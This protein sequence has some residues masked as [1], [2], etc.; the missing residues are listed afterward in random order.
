MF[1]PFGNSD[2]VAPAVGADFLKGANIHKAINAKEW[3]DYKR[4]HSP[5]QHFN[6]CNIPYLANGEV[7]LIFFKEEKNYSWL[8]NTAACFLVKQ[9]YLQSKHYFK[10]FF[11]NF[12]FFVTN[13]FFWRR[14]AQLTT[15]V[16]PNTITGSFPQLMGN[17]DAAYEVAER[18]VAYFFKGQSSLWTWI[19]KFREGKSPTFQPLESWTCFL[20]S[21][22]TSNLQTT[23][24]SAKEL[25]EET[26]RQLIGACS[27]PQQQCYNASMWGAG[28]VSL[29]Q[30]WYVSAWYCL[31]I[32]RP[33][34]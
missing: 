5:K 25:L 23:V 16:W 3:L 8:E 9:G 24:S 32:Y 17:V 28:M 12:F 29:T 33:I 31:A 6:Y 27:V 22:A 4:L 26:K 13:R 7:G 10:C 21:P 1:P 34:L 15:N 19:R 18:G 11:S 2:G 20:W 14:Q 30:Q